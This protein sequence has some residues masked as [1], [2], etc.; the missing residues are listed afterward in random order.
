MSP[1]KGGIFQC[2]AS[3]VTTSI[4]F[5]RMIGRFASAVGM[6]KPSPEIGTPR[7][8]FENL[9]SDAFVVEDLLQ[10]R[11]RAQFIPGR[12]GRVDA[13]VL[14]PKRPGEVGIQFQLISRK[15]RRGNRSSVTIGFRLR[16]PP[17][18]ARQQC[19]RG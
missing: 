14:L 12:I 16:S 5:S 18:H 15:A 13:P 7:R 10:E 2:E 8:I 9:V 1:L 19:G 4:W 6:R 3:L 11:G 17:S